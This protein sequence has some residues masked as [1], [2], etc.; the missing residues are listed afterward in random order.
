MIPNAEIIGKQLG[1]FEK[2]MGVKINWKQFDSGRDVNTA[3]AAGS[4]DMGLVERALRPPAS[5]GASTT[6]SSGF[7]TLRGRTKPW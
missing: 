5:P 6:K 7:T 4:L 1:W 2:E 3:M